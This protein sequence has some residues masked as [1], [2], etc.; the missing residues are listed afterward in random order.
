MWA[1]QEDHGGIYFALLTCEINITEFDTLSLQM[2]VADNAGANHD[3]TVKIYQGGNVLGEYRQLGAGD[4]VEYT[5][6]LLNANVGNSEDIAIELLC[7]AGGSNNYCYLHLIEAELTPTN[8][9][10]VN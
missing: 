8:Y 6:D 1:H 10:P 4:M 3:A 9:V 2:G 7:N 5:M